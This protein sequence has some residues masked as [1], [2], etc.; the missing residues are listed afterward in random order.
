MIR[1]DSVDVLIDL[2]GHTAGNRLLAFARK[3]V[4]V[5]A[6][7]LGYEGTTGLEAMDYLIAD[8]RLVP[9][10]SEVHY[11]ERVCVCPPPTPPTTRRPMRPTPAPSRPCA[12]AG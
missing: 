7:W 1:A 2:A 10:G 11:R 5:L 12:A 9:L 3:P 4:P 6:T 8:E